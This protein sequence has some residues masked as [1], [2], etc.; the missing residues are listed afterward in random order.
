MS[1]VRIRTV[2]HPY[3]RRGPGNVIDFRILHPLNFSVMAEDKI[4]KFWARVGLRSVS[5]VI[6]NC[7]PSEC[8][9]GHVTS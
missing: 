4:V 5:L 7:N 9:Q 1:S 3:K 2:D 6:T 8:G